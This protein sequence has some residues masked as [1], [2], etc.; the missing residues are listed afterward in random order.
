VSVTYLIARP[1]NVVLEVLV[2]LRHRR[3]THGKKLNS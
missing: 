1:V 2:N 3:A